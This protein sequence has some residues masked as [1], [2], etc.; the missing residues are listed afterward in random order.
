M[1]PGDRLRLNEKFLKAKEGKDAF[2]SKIMSGIL[3][4]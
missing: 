3:K 2:L 4:K 1:H